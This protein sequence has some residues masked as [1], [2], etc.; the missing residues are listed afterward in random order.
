MGPDRRLVFREMSVNG[1]PVEYPAYTLE[2]DGPV[3]AEADYIEEVLVRVVSPLGVQ[4]HWR[5]VGDRLAVYQPPVL[6]GVVFE[7]V[8]D[9]YLVGGVPREPESGGVLVITVQGPTEAVP[10]YVERLAWRNL[11]ALAMVVGSGLIIYYVLVTAVYRQ[12]RPGVVEEPRLW[13]ARTRLLCT[14]ARS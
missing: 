9:H 5:R 6:P 8:L 14:R 12:K 13:G 10:V 3:R 7:R 4:E 2:V 1:T 11:A